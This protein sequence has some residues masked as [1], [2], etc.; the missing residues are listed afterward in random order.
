MNEILLTHNGVAEKVLTSLKNKK[1][2][3]TLSLNQ[4]MADVSVRKTLRKKPGSNSS[5]QGKCGCCKGSQIVYVCSKCTHPTDP[6]QKQFWFC[7]TV[8]GSECFAKHVQ[9][10]HSEAN[11][12]GDCEIL[13]TTCVPVRICRSI[14]MLEN[15]KL[16]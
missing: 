3:L 13:H 9:D 16:F 1:E 8:E 10:K 2:E 7:K 12:G 15:R 11:G 4:M 5:Q 6:D 14:R